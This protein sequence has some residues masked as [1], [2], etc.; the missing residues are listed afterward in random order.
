MVP[1]EQDWVQERLELELHFPSWATS[2]LNFLL[3]LWLLTQWCFTWI[4]DLV[5]NFCISKHIPVCWRGS[6][7][8]Y[9]KLTASGLSL[10]LF[11]AH[12]DRWRSKN[13]VSFIPC[14]V[15]LS[16]QNKDE[17]KEPG[18]WWSSIVLQKIK[19][20][21]QCT[22]TLFHGMCV[23]DMYCDEYVSKYRHLPA[24]LLILSDDN[25]KECVFNSHHAGLVAK[26]SIPDYLAFNFW[27][28]LL[29]PPPF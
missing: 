26:L 10:L 28:G 27:L 1:G 20:S 6:S 24:I 7:H 13:C 29:F 18:N 19:K 8:S 17:E 25:S 9:S 3:V 4:N 5:W 2:L 23:C 12:Q 21:F 15:D 11:I 14:P 16:N 22:E